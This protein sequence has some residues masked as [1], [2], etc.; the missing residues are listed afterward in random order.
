[1]NLGRIAF[2]LHRIILPISTISGTGAALSIAVVVAPCSGRWQ[3]QH[4][5]GVSGQ[6]FTHAG[7]L[8][9]F[10]WSRVSSL[11]RFGEEGISR[12]L[13]LEW[14]I[15]ISPRPRKAR[16]VKDKVKCMVIVFQHFILTSATKNW[17]LHLDDAP[18]HTTFFSR[19][20]WPNQHYCHRWLGSS[21]IFSVFRIKD[22]DILTHL[23]WSRQN[24]TLY[25]TSSLNT[26]SRMHLKMADV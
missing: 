7:Y 1:M 15:P 16:Q 19:E 3:Y 24:C 14:K 11:M 10:I 23:R 4:I 6:N 13:V 8:R 22:T 17:L 12:T 9:P 26:T 2:F 21:A 20:F 18:S 5:L 25:W